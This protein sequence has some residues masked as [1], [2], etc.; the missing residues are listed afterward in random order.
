MLLPAIF[1]KIVPVCTSDAHTANGNAQKQRALS[2]RFSCET[3][4]KVLGQSF[5]EIEMPFFSLACLQIAG[6]IENVFFRAK[7]SLKKI[8]NDISS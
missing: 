8:R 1:L 2:Q 3:Q 6:L 4:I 7:P 5:Q